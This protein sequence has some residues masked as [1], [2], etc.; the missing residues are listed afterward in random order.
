[1]RDDA[2]PSRVRFL[3]SALPLAVSLAAARGEELPRPEHPEPQ[4]QRDSWASLNGSWE[5]WEG[6]AAGEE[7]ARMRSA[8]PDRIL[9]PFCRESALSGLR[10][11][12]FVKNVVYRRDFALP[13]GWPAGGR[14]L[15]HVGAGDWRTVVW[16]NGTRVGFHEGGNAPVTCE[17]TGALAAAPGA[18]NELRIWAFD[19]ALGGRQQLGKQARTEQSEGIFYTRTT[20]IWQTVWIERVGSSYLESCRI[21]PDRSNLRLQLA[22]ECVGD[23]RGLVVAATV[24]RDFDGSFPRDPARLRA[25]QVDHAA[26]Y[27]SR[28]STALTM[29]L[30]EG[31]EWSPERPH[32][33][34][35][36]LR[37][38]RKRDEGSAGA[39]PPAV[40]PGA[41]A[42]PEGD[43]LDE[44][45]AYFGMRSVEVRG[46]AV[47]LN[48]KPVFQRLVLDQGF[49]PEGVWTAPSDEA[50]RRDVE[51]SLAAGFNGARLHQ[52]VFEPRFHYWADRLGYLTWGE[53]PSY[54]A[55]YSDPAVDRVVLQEWAEILERDRNHPSIVGWCPFN[56]TAPESGPLQNAVVAVTRAIDP[57][58]PV[59]DTSG[60]VH[61]DPGRDVD[62]AHDYDQ[63]PVTFRARW[64][65]GA[66][67]SGV[68]ARYGIAPRDRPFFVSEF[69]GIGWIRPG[70]KGW[71]YGG[72]PRTEEE[73]FARFRGLCDAQLDNPSLFG[74]C[75]T[76]LTDVEQEKNGVVYYDRTPKFE[77]A[78]LHAI[79]ARPAAIETQTAAP[80]EA[81]PRAWTVLV[82]AAVDAAPA[83]WN[84]LAASAPLEG[85]GWRRGELGASARAG[86]GGFG[87]K[88]GFGAVVGTPWTS[89]DL[90][91]ARTFE[92]D[93]APFE[94][95][96][97]VVHYDNAT[98]VCVN[99][100]ELLRREG[101]NDRYE[102][103]DV[104]ERASALLRRGRNVI[105]VH[106]HQD[107]GGQYFDAALLV[108]PPASTRPADGSPPE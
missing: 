64:W 35:L 63:D 50:L 25:L 62:D 9:V 101:W 49:Y 105:A 19:D 18:R 13:A 43:L 17:I 48:G 66:A 100:G 98:T 90:Y 107:G 4:W 36:R 40:S 42:L 74:F 1:M 45:F 33:Y 83:E 3:L 34:G 93:G 65:P 67:A 70:E 102:P 15:L 73:W 47:L 85:E 78:R 77:M 81:A 10:R 2:R 32:L 92:W 7:E 69:G 103:I 86:R 54:G 31:S 20:G 71:G 28:G 41:V 96:L 84:Y 82:P 94:R 61:S 75:Y 95:A 87:N 6:D 53:G 106:V 44:V 55:N 104:T 23:P 24:T 91:L 11:T 46:A 68:P 38:L 21:V 58:R 108:A 72:V 29:K 51:I 59:L 22:P 97:L 80:P 99:G 26:G 52:K 39:A 27:A 88:D 12:G 8:F 5:F 60:Y 30:L 56:E 16:V 14:V 79:V 37:L 57:T 76:Q 89:S